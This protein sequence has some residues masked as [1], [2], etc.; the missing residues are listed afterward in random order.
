M[1]IFA[2][3]ISVSRLDAPYSSTRFKLEHLKNSALYNHDNSEQA[4]SFAPH[5]VYCSTDYHLLQSCQVS[6]A[7]Q[8]LGELSK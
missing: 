7:I 3:V 5:E 2:S 4:F 6:M 8:D 1:T